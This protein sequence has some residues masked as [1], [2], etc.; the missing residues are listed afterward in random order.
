M[1]KPEPISAIIERW[2]ERQT[3]WQRLDVSLKG[4]SLAAEIVADLERLAENDGSN[5]LSLTTASN[6]SGYSTD[7]LSRLIR[8]GTVPNAGRKGS[9]RIRRADLPMRP[10][11]AIAN[12]GNRCYSPDTDARSLQVRRQGA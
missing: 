3:E 10:S 11:A 4:A 9:P 1:S 5:E 12:A 6:L 8:E 2:K 7:H